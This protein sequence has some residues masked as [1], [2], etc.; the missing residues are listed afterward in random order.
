MQFL[1]II[2]VQMSAL[3]PTRGNKE[4][5]ME[6]ILSCLSKTLIFL[7]VVL[8]SLLLVKLGYMFYVCT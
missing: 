4:V 8:C 1:Q 5:D 2:H 7:C 3:V 6:I